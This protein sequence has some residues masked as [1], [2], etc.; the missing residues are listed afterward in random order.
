MLNELRKTLIDNQ[1]HSSQQQLHQQHQQQQQQKQPNILSLNQLLMADQ[2]FGSLH[3]SASTATL[4][5]LGNLTSSSL[6]T[7]ANGGQLNSNLVNEHLD[8]FSALLDEAA[9]L[10]PV[11]IDSHG[12]A[13][14]SSTMPRSVSNPPLILQ[15]SPVVNTTG[16]IAAIGSGVTGGAT[17]SIGATSG[18]TD[19][20][21]VLDLESAKKKRVAAGLGESSP[22]LQNQLLSAL[23]MAYIDMPRPLV[24]QRG[25][26]TVNFASITNSVSTLNLAI[27]PSSAQGNNSSSVNITP[28]QPIS[29]KYASNYSV[30]TTEFKS[31]YKILSANDMACLLLGLSQVDLKKRS[32]FDI[33]EDN[34]GQYVENII[35]NGLNGGQPKSVF[36]C[37][38][39]LPI[40]KSNGI[41]SLASFWVRSHNGF[42]SWV[43]NEVIADKIYLKVSTLDWKLLSITGD[44]YKIFTPQLTLPEDEPKLRE[45]SLKDLIPGLSDIDVESL[46]KWN[47]DFPGYKYHTVQAHSANMPCFAKLKSYDD[48]EAT[49]EI[50]IT[51]M[52]LMA[53]VIVI[54]RWCTVVDYNEYFVGTLLGYG[55]D[56]N[57]VLR[58]APVTSIIPRFTDYLEKVFASYQLGTDGNPLPIGLVIPEQA[59]RKVAALDP[60]QTND[61][62]LPRLYPVTDICAVTLQGSHIHVDIQL[63][64]V[65]NTHFALWVSYSRDIQGLHSE[66]E[67]PSQLSLLD[68]V[69]E[70]R[71]NLKKSGSG[72]GSSS[73]SRSS[74]A[75]SGESV[76]AESNTLT[77]MDSEDSLVTPKAAEQSD[78]QLSSSE[79]NDKNGHETDGSKPPAKKNQAVPDALSTTNRRP[80][81]EIGARRRQKSLK[82]FNIVQKLGEGAYGKV[83]LVQYPVEPKDVV[84]LK[85]VIKERILVDTWTRDRK[86]GTIPN[87]IKIMNN[88]NALPHKNIVRLIDFFEDDLY[89]HIEMERHGNPGTDLFDLIE[90]KPDMPVEECRQMFKQVT[91][92]VVHLHT[93]GII[94]RDIKDENIIV[95]EHGDVKLIDFGSAALTRQGPFDV[96]V[97]TIDYAAPE[98]LS[99]M[100]YEGKP[101]DVWALGIL[102]YTI[103][104]K[105]NP[106]YNVDEIMEGDLRLPYIPSESCVDLIQKILERDI[107]N[108]PNI[109]TIWE[110][111]WL[112]N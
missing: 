85:C 63:R 57:K 55:R 75:G 94:H 10:L 7:A 14:W 40:V 92:A 109:H 60:N 89:Y 81:V 1:A 111:E 25:H 100:P 83:L 93:H 90:L 80:P 5:I 102:L 8:A 62:D 11:P 33:L 110:H 4:S 76:S 86:L 101:Q 22:Q 112:Q 65:S 84:V 105:E 18:S 106:F 70:Y 3:G 59:F 26:S 2:A 24:F 47:A 32:I 97:G 82:D 42:I 41:H 46:E 9:E 48:F 99:G 43:L 53:G 12:G 95:D 15:G 36:I 91:S 20:R 16:S 64:V 17:P 6:K 21:A 50:S 78:A 49:A 34:Y 58:G 73:N 87:E 61:G 88:L 13:G 38:H 28:V 56:S 104:Y 30:F 98:V 37:G 51:S 31:P 54:D 72:G 71:A 69:L 27:L 67:M 107:R 39:I 79:T 29:S 44:N 66:Y 45:M 103:M 77:P 108:R 96:F 52:P 23:S 74:T 68:N 19:L 35:N